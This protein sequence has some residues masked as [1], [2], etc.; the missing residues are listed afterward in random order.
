MKV[1]AY[2]VLSEAVENGIS[3]GYS[4]AH[5]HD[6]YPTEDEIAFH[7]HQE[8]MLQICEYFQFDDDEKQ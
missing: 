1:N 8:I 6:E 5:K 3:Y 2:K 4:K 7:L